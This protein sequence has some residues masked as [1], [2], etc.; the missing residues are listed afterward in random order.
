MMVAMQKR[1]LVVLLPQCEHDCLAHL[2]VLAE[3]VHPTYA[4]HLKKYR[5][6]LELAFGYIIM[7]CIRWTPQITYITHSESI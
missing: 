3:V 4:R 5:N 7:N 6:L 1:Y 2:D